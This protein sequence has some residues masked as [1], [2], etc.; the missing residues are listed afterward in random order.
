MSGTDSRYRCSG[1]KA[2]FLMIKLVVIQTVTGICSPNRHCEF[3]SR[4]LKSRVQIG[5]GAFLT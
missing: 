3:E 4:R 5:K 1:C 2:A